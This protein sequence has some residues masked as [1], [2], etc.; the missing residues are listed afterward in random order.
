[1]T[2]DNDR[3]GALWARLLV[4]SLV[5]SAPCAAV[6]FYIV[7]LLQR[8]DDSERLVATGWAAGALLLALGQFLVSSWWLVRS[9]LASSEDREGARLVR[10][11]ELPRRIDLL[12]STPAWLTGLPLTSRS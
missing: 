12:A 6:A 2:R 1:M 4:R 10:L 5:A 9:A 3:A 8:L 7:Y 11:L